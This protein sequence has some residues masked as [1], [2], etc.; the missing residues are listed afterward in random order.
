CTVNIDPILSC[1]IHIHN[2]I[3]VVYILINMR[4]TTTTRPKALPTCGPCNPSLRRR[5]H[6]D[7]ISTATPEHIIT[8][9]DWNPFYT[10]NTNNNAFDDRSWTLTLIYTEPESMPNE[11]DDDPTRRD[12]KRVS[13][14]RY[15]R[16]GW[17]A[18]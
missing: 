1:T 12:T 14:G 2:I 10:L 13:L 6:P 8:P 7:Q 11:N 4:V 16:I 18:H 5:K 3:H 15:D 17:K 9:P